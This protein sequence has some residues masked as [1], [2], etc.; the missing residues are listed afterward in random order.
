MNKFSLPDERTLNE[1][2]AM[3][4]AQRGEFLL[5]IL[6]SQ[7]IAYAVAYAHHR[8]IMAH[9]ALDAFERWKRQYL[10]SLK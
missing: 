1:F 8:G 2:L 6:P 5:N 4:P 9:K 7:R 3:T 10:D